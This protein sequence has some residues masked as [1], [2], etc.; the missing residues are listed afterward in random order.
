MTLRNLLPGPVPRLAL[1]VVSLLLCLMMGLDILL[2]LTPDR[3]QDAV[4]IRTRIAESLAI[5]LTALMQNRDPQSMSDLLYELLGRDKELISV[6]VRRDDGPLVAVAGPHQAQWQLPRDAPSTI[7]EIRVPLDANGRHWGD[8]EMTFTPVRPTSLSGWLA[9]P[10][11]RAFII[12]TLAG[13]GLV[14]LYLRRALQ[15]LDPGAAV[16]QR[17][18]AAFDTLQEAVILLDAEQRVVL[19]NREFAQLHPEAG[20]VE[21]GKPVASLAWLCADLGTDQEE[22]PWQVVARSRDVVDHVVFSIPQ[23]G[24]ASPLRMVLNA[25]PIL[26]GDG[27]YRGCMVSMSDVTELHQTNEELR[28]TIQALD[29]SSEKIRQQNVE[30]IRLATTDPLTGCL[31]RR[32]FY[33]RLAPILSAAKRNGT[34]VGCIMTDIDFFKRFNDTYGHAVGDQVLIAVSGALGKGVR[35][36]DLLARFGGEEFCIVLPGQDLDATAIVAE[37]L[38]A[39]I[40]AT[41]G[42][43]LQMEEPVSVTSSFGVSQ[44][45]P[46]GED[47]AAMIHHA[48]AALYV[49]KRNGRN[50]VATEREVPE[51]AEIK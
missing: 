27:R 50:R 36:E 43:S 7:T 45:S 28:R 8:V 6:A 29:E 2:G 49:A 26:D 11:L 16:P 51:D 40:E 48:D 18:R 17:V 1:G 42:P 4:R 21:M 33:E 32:A 30:L 47:E 12:F 23:P 20:R 15:Y 13:A 10:V 34:P 31:N 35:E 38:R 41:A 39:A 22:W 9:D 37:R 46:G 25:S 14:Y 3:H 19:V 24:T 44:L 5:Q